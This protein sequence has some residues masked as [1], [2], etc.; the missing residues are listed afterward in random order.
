[1]PAAAGKAPVADDIGLDRRYL[2]LVIFAD[3]FHVGVGRHKTRRIARNELVCGRGSHRDC[4]PADDWCGSCPGFAP[5]GREFLAFLF[6]VGGRR[7]RR[8]PM[9]FCPVVEAGSPAQS[10]RP[11]SGAANQCDPC[12]HGSEIGLPGKGARKSGASSDRRAENWRWVIT[13]RAYRRSAWVH[14][15]G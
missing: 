2:D 6:L 5:P 8:S 4:R 1:M 13:E 9:T 7:L 3:Q 11:C 12:A 10:T 14:R 15:S